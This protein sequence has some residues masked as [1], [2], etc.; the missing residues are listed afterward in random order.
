MN[1]N[2]IL[3]KEVEI[4]S[5]QKAQWKEEV[6]VLQEKVNKY[7]EVLSKIEKWSKE[8][9]KQIKHFL[10]K[11][12]IEELESQLNYSDPLTTNNVVVEYV[13]MSLFKG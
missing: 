2:D 12:R 3:E 6:E 4:L 8:T 1:R 11:H 10:K 5:E 7:V 13:R 9:M